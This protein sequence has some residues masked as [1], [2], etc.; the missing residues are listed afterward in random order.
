MKIPG[1]GPGDCPRAGASLAHAL[2]SHC[3]V[4][5]GKKL[6]TQ[7]EHA[8]TYNSE[9]SYGRL[10]REASPVKLLCQ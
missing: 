9:A 4:Y 7:R 6:F 3:L 1:M 10:V 8:V 2:G 5:Q